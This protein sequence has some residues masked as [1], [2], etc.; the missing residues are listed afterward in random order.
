MEFR[1]L[2]FDGCP[3]WEK[4]KRNLDESLNELGLGTAYES[5]DVGQG[6]PPEHFY[7]SPTVNFKRK[8]SDEWED[9]FGVEG[10]PVMAC[11]PYEHVGSRTPHIPK[12]ML[13]SQIERVAKNGD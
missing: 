9:L 5:V 11:R 12:E 1:L 4:T 10:D 6:E 13:K 7:G 2:Y 3:G 8:S